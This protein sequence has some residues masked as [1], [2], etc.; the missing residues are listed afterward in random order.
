MN[1]ISNFIFIKL[2]IMSCT[3]ISAATKKKTVYWISIE[4]N[5]INFRSNWMLLI[6]EVIVIVMLEL[7][8]LVQIIEVCWCSV[9]HSCRRFCFRTTIFRSIISNDII[10]NTNTENDKSAYPFM[11]D[12]ANWVRI[13][14]SCPFLKIL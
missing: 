6:A 13:L 10:N 1:R 7:I 9:Y 12:K 3:K 5:R 2:W 8:F 11:E 14:F 4:R